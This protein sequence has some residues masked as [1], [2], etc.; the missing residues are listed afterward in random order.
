M[1][2][3]AFERALSAEILASEQMRIRVV[4]ATLA[5][6]L[7]L[8]QLIFL[9]AHDAVQRLMRE[10]VPT[11]LPLRLIGPFLAYEIVALI[12]LRYRVSRGKDMP[13]VARFA[14]AMVE[15]SL[16]TVI[17]WEANQYASP[18]VAFG[19]WPTMLYFLFIVASTLRL[20]FVLPAFTGAVAAIGYLGLV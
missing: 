15:T 5:L 8:D 13:A 12:V 9:L 11:W 19:T 16:P 4:A 7:V 14:N 20:D 17:L 6:L 10:P 3:S 2:D 18:A 1:A